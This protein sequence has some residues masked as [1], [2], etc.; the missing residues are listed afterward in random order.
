MRKKEKVS[1][2]PTGFNLA[3]QR[4]ITQFCFRVLS[5]L[6]LLSRQADEWLAASPGTDHDKFAI[7]ASR[8]IPSRLAEICANLAIKVELL[9]KKVTNRN[10]KR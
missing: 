8:D 6:S 9:Q 4:Q 7:Q 3:W 10:K 2:I 1:P 5:A